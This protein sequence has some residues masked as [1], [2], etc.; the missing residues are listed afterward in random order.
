MRSILLAFAAVLCVSSASAQTSTKTPEAI[1]KVWA[2]HSARFAMVASATHLYV[3]YYDA[4]RQLT[5]AQRPMNTP[6]HWVYHKVDTW[7]GW[8]SHNY[9][10]MALD[11]AGAV[12]VAA[13]MHVDP[14]TYFRSDP[15]GDVRTLKRV[16]V[17]VDPS[18]EKRMTYPIFLTDGAKRLIYK[19]RDGSSGDGNELY[20]V[21]DE[22]AQAWKALTSTPLVDGEGERNAYFMGPVLGPDGWFHIAW[23]WRET[24][25]A[26]TN[27][28]LSYAR[29]RDLI[30]WEKADGTPLALPIRLSQAEIVDPVPV[31]G[32][33]INN[34]TVIG[35]DGEGRVTITYHK[36]DA[37]GNTQIWLARRDAKGWT[38]RQIS[39]W[40]NYRWD[41]KGGGSLNSEI[42]V[43]G[44]HPG[45]AGQ[46]V[47][48]VVRLGQ[49]ID[50]IVD[51]KTLA[52]IEER[53][54]E[55]LADSVSKQIPVAEGQRVS[56]VQVTAPDGKTYTLAWAT[57]PP[58]RDVPQPT[59]PAATDLVLLHG[60][61]AQ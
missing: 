18:R 4:N 45:A 15:G 10:A 50:F 54:V 51:A 19:Y 6:A 9:I 49:S 13:N 44:A 12:H 53:K 56:T 2:G 42:F 48:P 5:I 40:S 39:A 17:M 29:T 36:Y 34:N 33:M 43:R 27:H 1:D 20:N 35:F 38:K 7:L 28:D 47:V 46:L 41:F 26:E 25:M 57:L 30:H 60:I 8:D 55:G 23:V 22:G 14:L 3:A 24:P 58:N 52:L 21:Y 59:I 16:S 11:G 61:G 31:K 37:A 32:G